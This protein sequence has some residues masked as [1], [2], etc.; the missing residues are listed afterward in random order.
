VLL[1]LVTPVSLDADQRDLAERL[2]ASLGPAN[3]PG[4]ARSGLF[5]RVRRAFR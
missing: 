5:E 3:E 1:K 2:D 4:A